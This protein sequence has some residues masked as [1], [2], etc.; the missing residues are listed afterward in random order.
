MFGYEHTLWWTRTLKPQ[1]MINTQMHLTMFGITLVSFHSQKS[2]IL[3]LCLAPKYCCQLEN[4]LDNTQLGFLKYQ[5]VIR[6]SFSSAFRI[7]LQ[8]MICLSGRGLR[9]GLTILP[10]SFAVAK[11]GETRWRFSRQHWVSGSELDS[12]ISSSAF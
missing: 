7:C 8:I 1:K 4:V 3:S 12:V 5:S 6:C 11:P 2:S 10:S 9:Q